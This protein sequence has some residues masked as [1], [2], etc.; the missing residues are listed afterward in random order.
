VES[1]DG[2]VGREEK[3]AEELR[4]EEEGFGVFGIVVAVDETERV[5]PR[6]ELT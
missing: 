6:D 4:E 2:V 3:E 1:G 5:E